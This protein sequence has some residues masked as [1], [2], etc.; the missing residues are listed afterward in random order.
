[1]QVIPS[2]QYQITVPEKDYNIL[3][4]ALGLMAGVEGVRVKEGD[5]EAA[6]DLSHR[7]LQQQKAYYLD[8]LKNIEGKLAKSITPGTSNEDG[9]SKS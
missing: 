8:R 1:M 9:T 7:M 4:R 3:I 5:A 2:P 6:A